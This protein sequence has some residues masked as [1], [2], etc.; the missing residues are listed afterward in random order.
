M[1]EINDF[2]LHFI[3]IDILFS[4]G[5]YS[6]L[7]F[8]LKIFLKNKERLLEFDKHACKLVIYI[9]TIYFF[10]WLFDVFIYYFTYANENEK[11]EFIQRLT[12]KYS[13][14]I[15]AQPVF[16]LILTQLLRVKIF[17]ESFLFR[18]FL[19]LS[20]LITFERFVIIVTSLHRDYLPSS[21]YYGFSWFELLLT[22]PLRILEF[23][24]IVLIYKFLLKL[25]LEFLVKK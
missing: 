17:R 2:T 23:I 16:W 24:V 20:F 14:G 8:I 7:Y 10:L 11:N 22:F 3:R 19:S 25:Y 6:V 15:W 12:G 13:F 1:L 5:Y 9:G 18:I 4:F 21:W